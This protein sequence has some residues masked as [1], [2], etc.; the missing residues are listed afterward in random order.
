MASQ[1]DRVHLVIDTCG[2]SAFW[3]M[4]EAMQH[5]SSKQIS[6]QT[7][8]I[9]YKPNQTATLQFEQYSVLPVMAPGECEALVEDLISDFTNNTNNEPSIVQH[10]TNLMRAFTRDWRKLWSLYAQQS[11]GIPHYQ[12]LIQVTR[13][14][15]YPN[16]RAITTA[17]NDIGVN[18]I[19]A[20]RVL[21]AALNPP[22]A[23]SVL[24]GISHFGL[25]LITLP[26]LSSVKI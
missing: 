14:Q 6:E 3:N 22:G 24:K 13:Q 4:V 12:Q 5:L 11:Q 9:D 21:N 23:V 25:T 7:E 18:A 26:L 19:F 16:M 15:M 8:L 10:Y 1:H 2:D 20:Q 17:S